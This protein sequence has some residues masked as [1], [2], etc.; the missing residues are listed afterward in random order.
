MLNILSAQQQVISSIQ[1]QLM[2]QQQQIARMSIGGGI[3]TSLINFSGEHDKWRSW[4]KIHRAHSRSLGYDEAF[5]VSPQDAVRVGADD[6]DRSSIPAERICKADAAWRSLITTCQGVALDLVLQSESPSEAWTTLKAHYETNTQGKRR[7]V[8]Q[9]LHNTS[10]V[11]GE[12][13]AEFMLRVDQVVRELR[14]L[15]ASVDEEEIINV[16]LKGLTKEYDDSRNLLNAEE[17]LTRARIEHVLQQR[18]ESIAKDQRPFRGTRVMTVRA[19]AKDNQEQ[20]TALHKP[21]LGENKREKNTCSTIH[22]HS[23]GWRRRRRICAICGRTGHAAFECDYSKAEEEEEED[24]QCWNC[25]TEGHKQWQCPER[26]K[27]KL[28]RSRRYQG[29]GSKEFCQSEEESWTRGR[30]GRRRH[31]PVVETQP[32]TEHF[33]SGAKGEGYFDDI[34]VKPR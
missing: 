9:E 30:S 5:D 24:R 1:Q 23:R 12:N 31:L 18:F 16:M 27:G 21:H 32:S 10:M 22:E 11:Q 3:V 15:G 28:V 20:T 8:R 17:E 4:S 2:A 25:G 34:I 13:P 19:A 7:Y 29:G 14:R 6:F 26:R 33:H